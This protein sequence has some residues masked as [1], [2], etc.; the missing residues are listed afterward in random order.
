MLTVCRRIDRFDFPWLEHIGACYSAL[1]IDQTDDLQACSR[2]GCGPLLRSELGISSLTIAISTKAFQTQARTCYS[3]NTWWGLAAAS[4]KAVSHVINMRREEEITWRNAL[5]SRCHSL[6]PHFPHFP[7]ALCRNFEVPAL[8]CQCVSMFIFYNGPFPH[9]RW[10]VT[11]NGK[12]SDYLQHVLAW[13]IRVE[14][15][16]QLFHLTKD[17]IGLAAELHRAQTRPSIG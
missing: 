10:Q 6:G 14:S 7:P 4:M 16:R 9:H 3:V 8:P 12:P 11:K 15:T 2:I 17:M 5:L 1:S 13:D